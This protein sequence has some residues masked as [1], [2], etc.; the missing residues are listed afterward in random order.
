MRLTAK[1][2]LTKFDANSQL[3]T[4]VK[5]AI[6]APILGQKTS[7]K[8]VEEAI[9]QAIEVYGEDAEIDTIAS[10]AR[11]KATA[12]TSFSIGSRTIIV[13]PFLNRHWDVYQVGENYEYEEQEVLSDFWDELYFTDEE[14]RLFLSEKNLENAKFKSIVKQKIAVLEDRFDRQNFDSLRMKIQSLQAVKDRPKRIKNIAYVMSEVIDRRI[15][16]NIRQ[17]EADIVRINNG[18]ITDEDYRKY[19]ATKI[20]GDPTNVSRLLDAAIRAKY[21]YQNSSAKTI[22]GLGIEGIIESARTHFETK[23]VGDE[24]IPAVE[25]EAAEKVSVLLRYFD[26]LVDEALEVL[27]DI[28]GIT[29]NKLDNTVADREDESTEDLYETLMSDEYGMSEEEIARQ[30]YGQFGTSSIRSG[31]STRLKMLLS[32]LRIPDREDPNYDSYD[33]I[34][35]PEYVDGNTAFAELLNICNDLVDASELLPRLR[36]EAKSRPWINSVITMLENSIETLDGPV[37]EYDNFFSDFWYTMRKDQ[38]IYSRVETERKYGVDVN[39]SRNINQFEG[40]KAFVDSWNANIANN[41]SIYKTTDNF[42]EPLINDDLTVNKDVASEMILFL[43]DIKTNEDLLDNIDDVKAILSMIGIPVSHEQLVEDCFR[44]MK[45]IAKFT[46][47][48]SKVISNLEKNDLSK[49]LDEN[50]IYKSFNQNNIAKYLSAICPLNVES[51]IRYSGKSYYGHTYPNFIGRFAKIVDSDNFR[52]T[53]KFLYNEYGRYPSYAETQGL[54]QDDLNN[55][56]L[57]ELKDKVKFK[58]IILQYIWDKA[59]NKETADINLKSIVGRNETEYYKMSAIDIAMAG[60]TN[61]FST[62]KDYCDF[63][64]PLE[65]DKPS[66]NTMSWKKSKIFSMD[67]AKL[68]INRLARK[69]NRFNNDSFV[70]IAYSLIQE[71]QRIKIVRERAAEFIEKVN[72][73]KPRPFEPMANYDA[74]SYDDESKKYVLNSNASGLRFALNATY[75]DIEIE[76]VPLVDYILNNLPDP[77]NEDGHATM[78]S[79]ILSLANDIIIPQ[80]KKDFEVCMSKWKSIGLLESKDAKDFENNPVKKFINFDNFPGMK[81]ISFADLKDNLFNYFVD[82]TAFTTAVTNILTNDLSFYKND[83]YVDAQKRAG[84]WHAPGQRVNTEVLR[85]INTHVVDRTKTKRVAYNSKVKMVT[86]PRYETDTYG[87]LCQREIIAKDIEVNAPSIETMR[88]AL[89]EKFDTEEDKAWID[90]MLGGHKGIKSADA[91]AYRS[92]DSYLDFLKAKGDPNYKACAEAIERISNG[93]ATRNDLDLVMQTFKPFCYGLREVYDPVSKT[94]IAAPVQCKNS[95]F[96][97]LV[98]VFS[99]TCRNSADSLPMRVIDQFMRD[100]NIHVI[101]FE[102]AIKA[103]NQ[104]GINLEA[105]QQDDP[106]LNITAENTRDNALY[107]SLENQLYNQDGSEKPDIIKRIPIDDWGIQGEQPE[108]IINHE[109]LRGSQIQKLITVNHGSDAEFD[110][111]GTTLT[112]AEW[113]DVYNKILSAQYESALEDIQRIFGNKEDLSRELQRM[114][115][116]STRYSNNMKTAVQI[117][118]ATGKFNADF[119]N[120]AIS[121]D[122]QM[123]LLSFIDKKINRQMSK[124]GSCIQVS[125]FGYADQLHLVFEDENGHEVY[126]DANDVKNS[127]ESIKAQHPGLHVKYMECYLPA[128]DR[129]LYDKL[130]TTHEN[131]DVTLELYDS[132]G[133]PRIP[134]EL[135]KAIGYRVPTESYYSMMPLRIKGFLPQQNGSSIMLPAEI[136]SLS[137]TDFD[138]DHMYI[139]LPTFKIKDLRYQMAVEDL[140]DSAKAQ[141]EDAIEVLESLNMAARKNKYDIVAGKKSAD[142]VKVADETLDEALERIITKWKKDENPLLLTP[143]E[144]KVVEWYTQNQEDAYGN[145]INGDTKI[146]E[147]NK[148]KYKDNYG[149]PTDPKSFDKDTQDNAIIELMYSVLTNVDTLEKFLTPGGF[150]EAS[151]TSR[152]VYLLSIGESN[153]MPILDNLKKTDKKFKNIDLTGNIYDII[154]S[155]N[156]KQL[157]AVESKTQ[158]TVN[159]TSPATYMEFHQQNM[160][161][162]QMLAIFAVA[163]SS[164]ALWQHNNAIVLKD[165]NPLFGYSPS[166]VDGRYDRK[167]ALIAHNLSVG[168]AGSADNV[169]DPTL[170]RMGLNKMTINTAINL[171]RMGYDYDDIAILLNQPIVKYAS[172]LYFA[173]GANGSFLG[174][175]KRIKRTLADEDDVF[176]NINLDINT[177]VPELQNVID[178]SNLD[179]VT[180]TQMNVL[181]WL[182]TYENAFSKDMRE[183]TDEAKPEKSF[184]TTIGATVD[185]FNGKYNDLSVRRMTDDHEKEGE[186]PS[187]EYESKINSYISDGSDVVATR[188][189][190]TADA[191]RTIRDSGAFPVTFNKC[192]MALRKILKEDYGV[193]GEDLENAMNDWSAFLRQ[194]SSGYIEEIKPI[195]VGGKTYAPQNI[196]DENKSNA[197]LLYEANKVYFQQVFPE[198]FNAVKKKYPF[199]RFK[200]LDILSVNKRGKFKI[201]ESTST[202]A[203]GYLETEISN[204]WLFMANSGDPMLEN[205]AKQLYMYCNYRGQFSSFNKGFACY[206]SSLIAMMPE[207]NDADVNDFMNRDTVERFLFQYIN[208]HQ[209]L[210]DRVATRMYPIKADKKAG[211]KGLEVKSMKKPPVRISTKEL[212]EY[213]T[214]NQTSF[215]KKTLAN[216]KVKFISLVGTIKSTDPISGKKKETPYNF[217]YKRINDGSFVLLPQAGSDIL[218]DF[219]PYSDNYIGSLSKGIFDDEVLTELFGIAN[220]ASVDLDGSN[221][222]TDKQDNNDKFL[223]KIKETQEKENLCA[224]KGVSLIKE[225]KKINLDDLM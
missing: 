21:D 219:N 133:N 20:I 223:A 158:I 215:L 162:K 112:E 5:K 175:L 212:D 82:Y 225:K 145:S 115:G 94:Y 149:Y 178:E 204:S 101:Q 180:E 170:A 86:K 75:N 209:E 210:L 140:S 191:I 89:R 9:K 160:V 14:A 161:G 31:A 49:I 198:V 36:E 106:E 47:E 155:M 53:V 171:L 66:M 102:S 200:I 202:R 199:G 163:L 60:I 146:L 224:L 108:H 119:D 44:G 206:G 183:Y 90:D 213:G 118:P 144:A 104:G 84:E 166:E 147:Y 129:A 142:G 159:P 123:L 113:Q 52:R 121:A 79:F 154:T 72:N 222:T 151:I 64:C 150:E 107:Q 194:F 139:M 35:E 57:S 73:G 141:E 136:V 74:I 76:G 2:S 173:G 54:S 111:A 32:S 197:E 18:N 132:E 69:E 46:A 100:N 177:L 91:Q 188:Q 153:L 63:V 207:L 16:E 192:T 40:K 33:D 172:N 99:K 164:H 179:S 165:L 208:N 167:G 137:G 13:D 68:K 134:E 98:S 218:D 105:F 216:G 88:A 80:L 186:E 70:Q 7:S 120:P 81:N 176:D 96:P 125:N 116:N 203:K 184:K 181:D 156:L 43:K 114:I 56:D 126:L 4:L 28:E 185:T 45:N 196:G 39:T 135:L 19:N 12:Y 29:V 87:H 26:T 83:N 42:S 22:N 193:F 51:S 6:G 130:L 157:K 168:V 48:V 131:G 189:N 41:I 152:R 24:D 8:I 15:E 214:E 124:G 117:N 71:A 55:K 182:I 211:I 37:A 205:F 190:V 77:N 59:C 138:I 34:D 10:F 220:F 187:L 17:T 67:R 97:I 65:S 195:K 148:Y 127:Y 95:E 30:T 201:I 27:S 50:K 1:C 3:A 85:R 38:I 221:N 93:N 62:E 122:L 110:V 217:Y 92:V 128:Y 169:K 103:S 143:N 25:G 23:L 174:I 11:A 58:N 109:Q 78:D 61:Y